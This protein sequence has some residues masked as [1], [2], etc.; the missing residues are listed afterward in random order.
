MVSHK[1]VG[2]I[3]TEWRGRAGARGEIIAQHLPSLLGGSRSC[4][5]HL[6]LATALI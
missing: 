5:L 6:S 4:D 3:L 1:M 2:R